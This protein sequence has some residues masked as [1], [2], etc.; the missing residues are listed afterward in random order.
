MF[1]KGAP[2]VLLPLCSHALTP[3]GDITE[4]TEEYLA[5]L[6]QLR[7]NW[8]RTSQRVLLLARRI[9]PN[10]ELVENYIDPSNI[11][12]DTLLSMT[13]DLVAVGIIGMVDRSRPEIPDVVRVCR[14]AGIRVVMVISI[15]VSSNI[16]GH[17]RLWKDS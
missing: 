17:R 15:N 5:E 10:T 12:E 7:T 11:A 3:S 13:K 8:A 16:T 9:V 14:G 2:D 6:K 1:V 4:M